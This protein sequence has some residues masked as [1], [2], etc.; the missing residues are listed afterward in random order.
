[1]TSKQVNTRR[2]QRKKHLK[3]KM[4]THES[5]KNAKKATKLK[6]QAIGRLPKCV[7]I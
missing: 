1:M 2:K 6:L 7:Q 4:R 5:M 3:M